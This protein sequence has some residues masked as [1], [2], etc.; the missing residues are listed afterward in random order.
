MLVG[1]ADEPGDC[2][3]VDL[4]VAD[5]VSDRLLV[6]DIVPVAE[7]VP[8][9][10]RLLDPVAL[11]LLEIVLVE[12]S[13]RDPKL[14]RV[15]VLVGVAK[16][17]L[18]T[19]GTAERERVP[20]LVALVVGLSIPARDRVAVTVGVGTAPARDRVA[21]TVGVGIAP[22]RDR[23]AVT[24]GVG[25]APAR[26]RVAVTVGVGTA[27]ARERVAVTV[28]VGTAPARERVAVT[29]GVG[30]TPARD[31]VAEA[32]I[33]PVGRTPARARD[34]VAVAVRVPVPIEGCPPIGLMITSRVNNEVNRRI[35]VYNTK[36]A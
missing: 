31:R 6:K 19:D 25:T 1:V 32:V 27:P 3:S 8:L 10:T 16:T 17:L 15:V 20:V 21:V 30:I 36:S 13:D 14:E 35:Y 26:E 7:P 22:A 34:R 23:V 4:G 33:V 18:D 5:V 12:L 11:R 24:V 9:E 29:V 28:G 2:V